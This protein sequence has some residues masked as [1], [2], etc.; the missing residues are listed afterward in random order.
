MYQYTLDEERA[1][2][3]DKAPTLAELEYMFGRDK[4]IAWLYLMLLDVINY[5]SVGD[6]LTEYQCKSLCES[7]ISSYPAMKASEVMLFFKWFK[8]A[9][10][11]RF[12]G[13]MD[14]MVIMDG[15]AKFRWDVNDIRAEYAR[16]MAS[17]SQ[18]TENTITYEEFLKRHPEKEDILK[19][20]IQSLDA[21]ET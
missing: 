16:K 4:A 5:F 12:Y 7:I 13:K 6:G 2:M 18:P 17:A 10:Y 21:Q 1:V 19:K 14:P 11:G 20:L 8:S 3:T 15:L 9:R